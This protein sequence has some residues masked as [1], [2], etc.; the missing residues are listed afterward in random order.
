MEKLGR[1]QIKRKKYY[2]VPR[3]FSAKSSDDT[4]ALLKDLKFV[5]N[6]KEIKGSILLRILNFEYVRQAVGSANT[7]SVSGHSPSVS[8][9]PCLLFALFREGAVLESAMRIERETGELRLGVTLKSVTLGNVTMIPN[10]RGPPMPCVSP[11]QL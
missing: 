10:E 11:T 7:L 9:R 2:L 3:M 1:T 4:R 5:Y 8:K 6:I